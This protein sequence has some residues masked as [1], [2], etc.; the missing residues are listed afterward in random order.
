MNEPNE[1]LAEISC[2][3]LLERVI[4]FALNKLNRPTT[5]R[6]LLEMLQKRIPVF[7]EET[8]NPAFKEV[9]ND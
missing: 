3:M 4:E 5:P 7:L 8:D 2:N 1:T 6:K 9:E